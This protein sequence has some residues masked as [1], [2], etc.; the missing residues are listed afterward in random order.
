MLQTLCKIKHTTLGK[1]TI[2]VGAALALGTPALAGGWGNV[3]LSHNVTSD[4]STMRVEGGGDFNENWGYYGFADFD[5]TP[6]PDTDLQAYAE[7]RVL[8]KFTPNLSGLLDVNIGFG[9][10]T[11][12]GGIQ[13]TP[14]VGE[15]NFLALR[16]TYSDAGWQQGFYGLAKFSEKWIADALLE[17]NEDSEYGEFGLERK[18]GKSWSAFGQLRTFSPS[19]TPSETNYIIGLKHDF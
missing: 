19:N 17:I 14:D 1:L 9:N 3:R 2:G 6:N 15:G 18:V 12:R 8:R 13:Y 4:Y 11:V 16:S 5:F 10:E 7:A